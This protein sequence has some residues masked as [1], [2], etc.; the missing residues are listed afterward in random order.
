[1]SILD[2]V[3]DEKPSILGTPETYLNSSDLLTVYSYNMD[4][5]YLKLRG[6]DAYVDFIG[7]QA[8]FRSADI[9]NN[10]DLVPIYWS[11]ENS[12]FQARTPVKDDFCVW[13]PVESERKYMGTVVDCGIKGNGDRFFSFTGITYEGRI[14]NNQVFCLDRKEFLILE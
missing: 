1:M 14:L 12:S 7:E 6:K 11:E 10:S 8:L 5:F 3:L 13:W 4:E 2:K 9:T